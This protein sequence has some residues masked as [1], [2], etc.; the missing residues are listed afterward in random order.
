[1]AKAELTLYEKEERLAFHAFL[2]LHDGDVNPNDF[3]L[4]H[5]LFEYSF[6]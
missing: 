2:R 3:Q 5:E 6:D 1:M 4:R